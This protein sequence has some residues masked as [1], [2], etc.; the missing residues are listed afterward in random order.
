MSLTPENFPQAYAQLTEPERLIMADTIE[1]RIVALH[2][3]KR[4]LAADLLAGAE[5]AG[6]L[7]EADLSQLLASAEPGV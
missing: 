3:D 4:D 7:G 2:R 5:I 1:Q 6:R